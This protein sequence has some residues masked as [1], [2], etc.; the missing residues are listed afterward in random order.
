MMPIVGLGLVVVWMVWT[1]RSDRGLEGRVIEKRLEN[2]LQV[3][4]VER[5]QAPIVSITMVFKAGAV[6]DPPGASGTAHIL[7]HMLFRGTKVI[8]TKDYEAEKGLLDE[9]DRTAMALDRE[10]DLGDQRDVGRVR[11]LRAKLGEFRTKHQEIMV[12]Q[13][14]HTLYRRAGAVDLNAVTDA[15]FTTYR[16]SLPSNRIELWMMIES[17]RMKEP[18]LRGF[19][20]EREV[21]VEERRTRV[22]D[23][24]YGFL[25]EQFLAAAF[26]TH[27]YR[28]PVVGRESEIRRLTVEKAERFRQGHYAPNNALIGMVGDIDPEKIVRQMEKYFGGIPARPSAPRRPG[29]EPKQQAERRIVVRY[30][31]EPQLIIGFRKP[32]APH[33]DDYAFE[34]IREVLSMN[35]YSRLPMNLVA[36]KEIALRA[37][38]RNAVPGSRYDNLFL[39]RA[40]PRHPHGLAELESAIL[41]ELELLK[42]APVNEGELRHVR[43]ALHYRTLFNLQ[44]NLTLASQLSHCA[45][46]GDWRYSI[47]YPERMARVRAR[48]VQRVA[49][50]YLVAENRTV[51][52]MEKEQKD[53]KTTGQE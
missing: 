18:V 21:V 27:P 43:Q 10:M 33:P 22:D 1:L 14:L 30:D 37:E 38:A 16:V 5:H 2:G 49:R 42:R 36:G 51:A 47:R 50:T 15:D 35:R 31:A 34:V 44:S 28:D 41:D 40:A 46:L 39:I 26:Q 45:A 17:Q 23:S 4:M 9:I 25:Y 48:D 24:A 52:W 11:A 12:P 19:Y 29:P 53:H 13:E 6:D 20:K 7:E 3:L 8:G 32:K